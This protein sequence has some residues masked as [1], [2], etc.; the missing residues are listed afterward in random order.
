M[1]A[2]PQLSR[3]HSLSVHSAMPSG[4]GDEIENFKLQHLIWFMSAESLPHSAE[5]ICLSWW[6]YCSKLSLQCCSL[7][8]KK[9]KCAWS[10]CS[11]TSHVYSLWQ[12]SENMIIVWKESYGMASLFLWATISLWLYAFSFCKALLT[13]QSANQS[14]L[15]HNNCREII[16]QPENMHFSLCL[17]PAMKFFFSV[18]FRI[19]WV[20]YIYIKICHSFVL[21]SSLFSWSDIVLLWEKKSGNVST[22]Q[23]SCNVS[24]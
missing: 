1:A 15:A 23:I 8:K 2:L 11:I 19:K 13:P 20:F 17:M 10:V 7:R 14:A 24:S 21:F 3:L 18:R 16:E 9:W 22:E 5:Y 6:C 4:G 12:L